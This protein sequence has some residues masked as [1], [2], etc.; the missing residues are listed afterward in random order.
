MQDASEYSEASFFA[1]AADAFVYRRFLFTSKQI[2]KVYRRFRGTR[3]MVRPVVFRALSAAGT[4]EHVVTGI[5]ESEPYFALD[6]PM[7]PQYPRI[8][9]GDAR[10]CTPALIAVAFQRAEVAAQEMK[11]RTEAAHVVLSAYQ[12]YA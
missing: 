5:D 9:V 11:I 1:P 12:V 10:A 3:I 8:A 2:D 4:L 7:F 6:A